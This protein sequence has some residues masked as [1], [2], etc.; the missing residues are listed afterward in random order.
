MRRAS[1]SRLSLPALSPAGFCLS[2]LWLAALIGAAYPQQPSDD[3]LKMLDALRYGI[4]SQ[5]LAVVEQLR[6]ARD[7]SLG[8]EL[9]AVLG[10]SRSVEVRKSILELFSELKL[11]DGEETARAILAPAGV[12]PVLAAAAVSYLTA[13][14][15]TG[16]TTLLLPLVDSRDA[17]LS[18]TAIR[19]LGKS[20]DPAAVEPLLAKLSSSSF[21]E[22]RK[23]ELISAL[24]ELGDPR[25]VDPLLALAAN[26]DAEKFERLSAIEAL[27]KLGDRKALAT[28][29]GLFGE[30]DA[31]VRAYAAAALASLSPEEALPSLLAGLR[32]E[33][34]KVR[35]QCAKA[36]GRP[37][38]A[39]QAASVLPILSWK[40]KN[41]PERQVRLEAVRSLGETGSPDAMRF[42][43]ELFADAG[44]ALDLRETALTALAQKGLPESIAT[45]QAVVEGEGAKD[46]KTLAMVAKVLA[47]TKGA[48]LQ[49]LYERLLASQD[50][51]VRI[52]AIRGV[53]LNGL[54]G[55]KARLSELEKGDPH[56]AVKSEAG[57]A[58]RQMAASGAA[59]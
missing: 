43:R 1:R 53:A 52:A 16:I 14:E 35:L 13:I 31:L 24:G 7:G 29:Q 28:L 8:P 19:A 56:P 57:R 47:S 33:N 26:A 6:D 49:A 23:G 3:R 5:V 27:G 32:D 2:A 59:P 44:T 55:L 4:D 48:G 58:L 9:S 34:V 25:A 12:S 45:I 42:L 36:L 11:R 50:F 21:P 41:D 54:S 40:A 10:Q 39:S 37:L 20:K 51:A 46:S 17:P 18:A 22:G 30:D 38:N 15:A